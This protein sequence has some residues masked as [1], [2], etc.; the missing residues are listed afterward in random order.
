[1]KPFLSILLVF[2]IPTIVLAAEQPVGSIKTLSGE[3]SIVRVNVTYPAA[4][5]MPVYQGDVIQTSK[6]GSVG[7][8]FRDDTTVSIGPGSTMN[9]KKYVFEPK[10]NQFSFFMKFV[11]GTF[12]YVSGVIGKLSPNSINIETPTSMIGVRGTKILIEVK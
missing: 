4:I 11:K 10:D 5:G 6:S 1:M 12:V 3:A 7:I 9:L 8:I 2:L